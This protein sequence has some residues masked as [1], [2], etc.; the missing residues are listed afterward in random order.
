M[1]AAVSLSGCA[2]VLTQCEMRVEG[3][4][5]PGGDAGGRTSPGSVYGIELLCYGAKAPG[6]YGAE[7]PKKQESR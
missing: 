1:M 6:R 5:W 3:E 4:R 7:A 2:T